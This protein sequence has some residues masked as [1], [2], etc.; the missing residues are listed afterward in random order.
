MSEIKKLFGTK[1]DIKTRAQE[2]LSYIE[3]K[4]YK[5]YHRGAK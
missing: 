5:G 1:E 3:S 4:K 2:W